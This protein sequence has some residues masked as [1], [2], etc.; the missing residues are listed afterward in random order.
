[1]TSTPWSLSI[2]TTASAPVSV[3]AAV[4][5]GLFTGASLRPGSRAGNEVRTH[6]STRVDRAL[7]AKLPP[8]RSPCTDKIAPPECSRCPTAKTTRDEHCG[9]AE[10]PAGRALPRSRLALRRGPGR[11]GAAPR[12]ARLPRHAALR[13]AGGRRAGRRIE[14]LRD[15]RGGLHRDPRPDARH[16]PCA[17]HARRDGA[18]RRGAPRLLRRAGRASRAS[19]AGRAWLLAAAARRPRARGRGRQHRALQGRAP[20]A[21]GDARGTRPDRAADD[22]RAHLA[23]RTSRAHERREKP[24]R[25]VRRRA[26][27]AGRGG[28]LGAFFRAFPE[29]KYPRERSRPRDLS[30]AG[31]PFR[32]ARRR[33]LPAG[34][35]RLRAWL[36]GCRRVCESLQRGR[37]GGQENRARLCCLAAALP[38]RNMGAHMR[39]TLALLLFFS[40]NAWGEA[41]R[42][43]VEDLVAANRILAHEGVLAEGWGHVSVRLSKDRFLISQAVAPEMV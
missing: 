1:M 29:W 13:P 26:R 40:L 41:D 12:C 17:A 3:A 10:A 39:I 7:P 21:R 2:S 20:R 5:T 33:A 28:T 25:P 14:P 37:A 18:L 19:P 30:Y 27:R 15:A 16:A 11:G 43:L 38:R 4:S 9:P 31:R 24:A 22:A 36:S 8:R 23:A 34:A 35:R 32:P 42:R 6:A